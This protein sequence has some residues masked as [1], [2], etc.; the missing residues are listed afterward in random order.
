MVRSD[1]NKLKW[2]IARDNIVV[3]DKENIHICLRGFDFIQFHD[4]E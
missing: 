2:K 3:E 1:G 4:F